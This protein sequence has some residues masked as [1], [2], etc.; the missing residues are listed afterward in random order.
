M[1]KLIKVCSTLLFTFLF[2]FSMQA[3]AK[4][5]DGDTPAVE[6]VC[7]DFLGAQYGLCVAYCEAMDCGDAN[8]HAS[9]QACDA[10]A[11]NYLRITGEEIN[12]CAQEVQR[13]F[14]RELDGG[15]QCVFE[16][17]TDICVVGTWSNAQE[18]T[19]CTP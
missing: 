4:T 10:V 2:A 1:K 14:V 17:T 7:D 18:D 6:T 16:G 3:G 9:D 11:R 19:E 15:L 12:N 8:Q 13:C 5:P